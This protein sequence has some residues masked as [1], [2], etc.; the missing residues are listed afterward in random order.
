MIHGRSEPKRSRKTCRVWYRS[1]VVP[2]GDPRGS[3]TNWLK[4]LIEAPEPFAVAEIVLAG[5]LRMVT[6]PKIF[7]PATPMLTA[8]A[9]L[10]QTKLNIHFGVERASKSRYH[11]SFPE[12]QCRVF[13]KNLQS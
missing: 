7:R 10:C 3:D 8:L 1:G 13:A 6:N 12:W 11:K 4:A 2:H 5:L 9:L